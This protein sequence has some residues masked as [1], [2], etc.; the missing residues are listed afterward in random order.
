MFILVLRFKS[1]E[2]MKFE[3]FLVSK[4]RLDTIDMELQNINLQLENDNLRALILKNELEVNVENERHKPEHSKLLA[5]HA[6][7]R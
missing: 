3:T 2:I 4:S 1:E 7:K 6:E 5:E